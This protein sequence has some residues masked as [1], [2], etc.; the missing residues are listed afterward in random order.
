MIK[1]D[2]HLHSSFSSDSKT[3]MEDQIKK[4]I[5]LGLEHLCFTEHLDL[6]YPKQYGDF[7]LSIDEY[8]KESSYLQDK[9]KGTIKIYQGIEFGLIPKASQEYNVL[10]MKYPFD[11]IIGSTHII[12]EFDPYYS[13]YWINKSRKQG[14]VEY[15]NKVLEN[16]KSYDEYDTLGHLDYIIR[17]ASLPENPSRNKELF[18][19]N[20]LYEEY[21]EVLDEILHH[22]IEKDKA[23]EVNS[24]GY[25]Y[26]L[27]APNPGYSVLKRYKE[28]GGELITIGSDAHNPEHLAYDFKKLEA[29]LSTIGFQYYVIYKNREREFLKI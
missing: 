17:Y 9:Y 1:A 29:L 2:Y 25:K 12:D 27:G 8:F 3:P 6:Y 19:D 28:M 18:F 13:D 22:L 15:F 10:V 7:S 14:I 23:L 21:K 16:I 24:G 4:A 5:Q 20:Y 26:G 11:F